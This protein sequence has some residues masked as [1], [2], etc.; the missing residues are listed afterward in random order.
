MIVVL[1]PT[2]KIVTYMANKAL[3]KTPTEPWTGT[4]VELSTLTNRMIRAMVKEGGVGIAAPQ[5]G[6]SKS[7]MVATKMVN[8]INRHFIFVNPEILEYSGAL[9]DVWEG[10]LSLPGEKHQVSRYSAIKMKYLSETLHPTEETFTGF[11]AQVIQHEY[12]HLQGKMI[13][14]KKEKKDE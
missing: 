2:D 10:C 8:S 11:I 12:D 9:Y 6:L 5:L 14:D 13:C 4:V 7:V 3:L 1:Q